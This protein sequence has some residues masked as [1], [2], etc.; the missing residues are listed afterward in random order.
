MSPRIDWLWIYQVC[1]SFQKQLNK[2]F[3]QTKLDNVDK[4]K[5][6]NVHNTNEH[7]SCL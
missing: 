4:E 3:R 7:L 1:M 2:V 5:D 6:T